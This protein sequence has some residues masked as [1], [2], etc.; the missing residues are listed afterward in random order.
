MLTQPMPTPSARAASQRFWMAQ[1]VEYE[2]IFGLWVRPSTT[3]PLRVGSQVT[4]MPSGA[5]TMPSSL[6]AR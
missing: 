4:H 2:S 3:L 1:T 6:R 5:S